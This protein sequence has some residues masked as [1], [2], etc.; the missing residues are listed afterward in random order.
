MLLY[1]PAFAFTTNSA[2]LRVLQ[3]C[4]LITG[5]NGINDSAISAKKREGILH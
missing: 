5:H 3:K 1:F 4:G 2:S